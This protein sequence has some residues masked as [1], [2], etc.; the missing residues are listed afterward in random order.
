MLNKHSKLWA[1]FLKIR[2]TSRYIVYSKTPETCGD[3]AD[4]LKR[5]FN[6]ALHLLLPKL[7][8]VKYLVVLLLWTGQEKTPM[9]QMLMPSS[10]TW[11]PSS[12]LLILIKLSIGFQMA[13]RSE[14][15]LFLSL[16]MF[17]TN[18][19]KENVTLA[20]IPFIT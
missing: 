11:T 4:L 5:Y 3:L 2:K 19:T 6:P 18:K 8:I 13:F 20:T 12:L 17:W 14:I 7:T 16:E 1:T 10:L 15:M 9:Q